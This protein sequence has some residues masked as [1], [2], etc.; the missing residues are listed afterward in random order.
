[1]L[2]SSPLTSVTCTPC[3][4]MNPL[5]LSDPAPWHHL[6]SLTLKQEIHSFN[7]VAIASS[8]TSFSVCL[9]HLFL[10]NLGTPG[11]YLLYIV[12][13][14]VYLFSVHFSP[15]AL[16]CASINSHLMGVPQT[17]AIKDTASPI[18]VPILSIFSGYS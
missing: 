1:M 9:I 7:S 16:F 6:H 2:S 18:S 17:L 12:S 3:H 11:S 10:N 5:S 14:F 15:G 4:F 13:L 8:L